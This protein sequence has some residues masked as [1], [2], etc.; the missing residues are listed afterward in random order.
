MGDKQLSTTDHNHTTC[1]EQ[2]LRTLQERVIEQ[3]NVL[4][5]VNPLH[6]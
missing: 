3:E 5:Q 4:T 6:P 2:T 1:L